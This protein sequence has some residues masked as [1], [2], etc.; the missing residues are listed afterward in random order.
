MNS[1]IAPLKCLAF[2]T[3]FFFCL[4]SFAFDS[5]AT[6]KHA[7]SSIEALYHRLDNM[8]N[9]SMS[10]RIDWISNQFLGR[11]YVP[12][13]LGEG[14]KAR[15][16]Q[17]PQYRVDVFDCDTYVNTVLSLALAHSV[18][19]FQQCMKNLRYKD[20]II[21]YLNRNHFT[22]L[23][24]NQNTQK[25][26][27]L[28][29]ITLAIKDKNNQ[30]IAQLAN[31]VINKPNWYAFKIDETIRLEKPDKLK[32]EER[33]AE[34]KRK[35]A[36]L[37]VAS[38]KIPYLPFTALFPQTNKPDMYLFAQIPHGA[39]IE[40]VRPNWDLRKNI[41]TALNISHLGFAIWN[42]GTLYF[43]QASSKSGKVVE[44]P[45]IQYLEKAQNSPTIKGINIQ[46]VLPSKPLK[47][48]KL[49]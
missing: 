22:G 49:Q 47:K 21:S 42:K 44:V 11:I 12:G 40:I 35:G 18:S 31:A 29:D 36:Q 14:S 33:L 28:K 1:T 45:L 30:P 6:E 27:I 20:G 4:Q 48:C 37:Q 41:G 17:F 34:L 9:S 10:E 26:G 5:G 38:E 23:D 15:Y 43:R 7:N 25:S 16:D 3:C 46:I 19:S 24:W 2:I 13:S 32:A 39:I 8:P